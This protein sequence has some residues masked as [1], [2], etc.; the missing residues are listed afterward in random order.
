MK[1]TGACWTEGS[2]GAEGHLPPQM[3]GPCR[4]IRKRGLLWKDPKGHGLVSPS[5]FLAFQVPSLARPQGVSFGLPPECAAAG[6]MSS[7]LGW[8]A[9]RWTRAA[10]GAPIRGARGG[11]AGCSRRM[12]CAC[13]GDDTRGQ[14]S[15]FGGGAHPSYSRSSTPAPVRRF[16]PERGRLYVGASMEPAPRHARLAPFLLER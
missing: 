15:P 12:F 10:Q 11:S 3:A 14:P 4:G 2:A 9:P 13:V 6:W 8:A 5:Q 1:G 16:A 7:C